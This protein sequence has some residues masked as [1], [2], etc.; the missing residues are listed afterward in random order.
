MTVRTQPTRQNYYRD[1]NNLAEFPLAILGSSDSGL[2]KEPLVFT[3]TIFDPASQ[4]P[5]TRTLKVV[6]SGKYGPPTPRDDEV[7]LGIIQLSSKVNFSSPKVFFKQ[8]ELLKLLGWGDGKREYVR[9]EESLRRFAST[10]LEYDNAWWDAEK[11][12]WATCLFHLFNEVRIYKRGDGSS[13]VEGDLCYVEWNKYPF[14]SFQDGYLRAIDLDLFNSLRSPIAKRIYRFLGKRFYHHKRF[15]ME[16]RT[17]AC[18]KIGLSKQA[19]NP[20]LK[21]RLKKGIDELIAAGFIKKVKESE[22]YRKVS[23]GVWNIIVEKNHGSSV[24]LDSAITE[25]GGSVQAELE[26]RG[27]E[28]KVAESLSEMHSKEMIEEKIAY[29]D[30]LMKTRGEGSVKNPAGFLVASLKRDFPIGDGIRNVNK[31]VQQTTSVGFSAS[32]R[33]RPVSDAEARRAMLESE[34]AK[35]IENYWTALT[36]EEREEAERKALEMADPFTRKQY[37]SRKDNGG[38]LFVAARNSIIRS[39]VKKELGLS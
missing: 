5:V 11:Q 10:T 12:R 31:G 33:Q 23:H 2:S 36:A 14:K 7:L 19:P 17:F 29:F 37:E 4:R 28:K 38:T 20:E 6:P 30:H 1:E 16:L 27:I 3:D 32:K 18:E 21:R 35:K 25:S 22:R 24:S 13:E 9:L 39:F 34:E 8:R 15:E 26:K